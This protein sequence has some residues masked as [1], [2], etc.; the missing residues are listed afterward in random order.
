MD[1]Q[2]VKAFYQTENTV[3]HHS[4]NNFLRMF[5]SRLLVQHSSC[6]RIMTD[7]LPAHINLIILLKILSLCD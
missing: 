7:N 2:V 6:T 1:N 4:E 5:F 3:Y